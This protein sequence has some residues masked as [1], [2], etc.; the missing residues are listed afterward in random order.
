MSAIQ[1]PSNPTNGQQYSAPNGVVYTWDGVKWLGA[2]V[3]NTINSIGFGSST[4]YISTAGNLVIPNNSIITQQ[5]GS[6]A[7]ATVALLVNNGKTLALNTS[8]SVV[9]PDSTV[10]TTAYL[11][12]YKKATGVNVSTG[13]VVSLNTIRVAAWN[14]YLHLQSNTATTVQI[15]GQAEQLCFGSG[16]V[17]STITATIT[18]NTLTQP[19]ILNPAMQ[20]IGDTH[21]YYI[22]DISYNFMYRVTGM[23]TGVSSNT[24]YNIVIEQLI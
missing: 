2:V 21:L 12:N 17:A 13:T 16:N 19:G 7:L 11:G 3:G 10:Q 1:F 20:R 8:G 4:I 24:N 18:T 23:L 15:V 22:T 6:P 5:D 9:F 14:G